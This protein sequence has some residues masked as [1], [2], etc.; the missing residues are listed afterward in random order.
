MV[1]T[2][3]NLLKFPVLSVTLFLATFSAWAQTPDTLLYDTLRTAVVSTTRLAV[4][5]HESVLSVSSLGKERLRTAQAQL[6]LAE[7][8]VAIPGVVTLGDANFSQDL[9]ISI[10]GF[11]ARAGFGIR[12]IKLLLDGIPES[13]PDG[14]GQVDNLDPAM[15]SRLEVLRGASGGLWGN[16]SGGVVSLGTEP[17]PVEAGGFA[18]GRLAAGSFGLSQ[19]HIKAGRRWEKVGF[20][21]GLT[22]QAIDGFRDHAAM[23]NTMAHTKIAWLPDS[24][25]AW[26]LLLNYSDSPRADDPGAL[27]AAQADA[28]PQSAN[29]ANLKF[30]A[31]ESLR[32]GRAAL[33]HEKKWGGRHIL[34][35][36]AYASGR[37]FENRLPFLN[38]GQVTFQRFFAG[39]GAQ[40]E[41][42]A[43]TAPLR[44]TAGVDYDRQADHRRRYQNID[45]QRGD[46]NLDQTETFAGTGAYI[47]GRWSPL[48]RLTLSGGLRLDAVLLRVADR[49]EADGDQSGRELFRQASPWAGFLLRLNPQLR[50]FANGTTN[51]ETPTLSELSNNPAGTGGF[52]ADLVPQRTFSVEAGLRGRHKRGRFDWELALFHAV[53]RDELTPFEIAGQPGRTYYRNAGRVVRQGAEAGLNWFPARGLAILLTYAWSDFYFE[54]FN[55]PSGDFAGKQ[56]PLLPRHLGHAELRWYHRSGLFVFSGVRFSGDFFADDNN[57]ASV[58]GWALLKGRAGWR[59]RFGASTLEV[60]LGSDNAADAGWYNSVRANAAGGRYFEPGAGRSWLS[61]VSLR[62]NW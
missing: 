51:F 3:D 50:F 40:Y 8:L 2:R 24:S 48:N 59:H 13:A 55:T 28:N 16:A 23:R 43:R 49:F 36:R 58:K 56:L 20:V 46:R 53:T 14:Q 33:L 34:R 4:P 42:S 35:L 18:E 12:G 41:W 62:R 15:I 5:E 44:L 11:G 25:A 57:T 39:G 38:G 22:R 31:G 19:V 45:G 52:S 21:A 10:R 27:D 7:S 37:D 6:T 26:T 9:R 1:Q 47:L 30:N 61:G 54:R 17:V 60:F 32:Q 29:A